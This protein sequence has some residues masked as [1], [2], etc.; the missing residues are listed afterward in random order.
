MNHP[1]NQI[2]PDPPGQTPGK[3]LAPPPP[4]D[5]RPPAPPPD[6]PDRAPQTRPA[7]APGPGVA[8]AAKR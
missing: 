7:D 1:L 6:H 5:P 8:A 2:A 4:G 3:P